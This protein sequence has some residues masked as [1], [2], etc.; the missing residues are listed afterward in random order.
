MLILGSAYNKLPV[1][2]LRSGGPIGRVVGH[3]IN[4]HKLRIDALW[5]TLGGL[6]Q[7]MLLP[8]GEIRD[9]SIKLGV[10]VNDTH[11][12]IEPHDAL[13]LKSI[14]DLRYELLGKKVIAGRFRVGKV[15]DYAVD[16][17][18]MQIMKLYAA[19]SVWTAVKTTQLSYD[20]SQII[21]VSHAYVKVQGGELKA[22]RTSRRSADDHS[23]LSPA[24]LP[25]SASLIEE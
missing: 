17:D 2:C 3:L 16:R 14:I 4:P 24:S 1:M 7:P 12:L 22:E 21:E 15:T 13:R 20:R 23:S 25:S 5:C 8:I 11:S 19:P 10:I 18:S 9:Q 6:K